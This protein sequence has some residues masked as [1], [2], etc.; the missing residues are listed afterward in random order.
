MNIIFIYPLGFENSDG[1]S[2]NV[3]KN[4]AMI[5]IYFLNVV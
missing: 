1:L 5:F 2:F 3:A 4:V